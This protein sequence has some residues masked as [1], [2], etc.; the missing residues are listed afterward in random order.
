[1]LLMIPYTKINDVP[2]VTRKITLWHVANYVTLIGYVSYVRL[3]S[4]LNGKTDL[5]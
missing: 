4:L 1:M 3:E 2:D 5:D